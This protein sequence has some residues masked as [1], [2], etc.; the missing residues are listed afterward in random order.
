MRNGLSS[1]EGMKKGE[2]K[3]LR[4]SSAL[5]RLIRCYVGD[6]ESRTR[7]MRGAAEGKNC[8]CFVRV[9]RR[10]SM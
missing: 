5:H 8:T 10:E 4:N 6:V 2:M 1:L 3:Q 7:I 9:L